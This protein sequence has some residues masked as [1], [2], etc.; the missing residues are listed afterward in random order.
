[1]DYFT[2]E[3]LQFYLLILVRISAFIFIAPFFSMTNTPVKVKTGF[4]VFVSLILFQV[5]DMSEVSYSGVIGYGFLVVQEALVGLIIGF[6]ANICNGIL[7]FT[8]QI[9]D[10]EVGFSMVNMFDPVSKIQT[11]ITG[12]LYTYF[13]TLMLLVT[14]MHH[15]ILTALVMAYKIIPVGGAVFRPGMHTIMLRF[16]T[17]YFVIGFRIVLPVFAATLLLNIILGIL[18]RVA[19]QMNMFVIGMQLKVFC[20]L[21]IIYLI[22]ILI[23]SVSGFI[24]REMDAM[25]QLAIK[26]MS[27]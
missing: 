6:F 13:V 10:M 4:S 25:M 27:P 16:M 15:Y 22:I 17:D 20:G 3:D 5:L 14:N 2:I 12:N 11:T 7:S 18:A 26:A 21:I 1:M 23:P 19:P 9:I 24:F 8:G